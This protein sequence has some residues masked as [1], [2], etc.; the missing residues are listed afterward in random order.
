MNLTVDNLNIGGLDY[1]TKEGAQESLI[2]VDEAQAQV[3]S[4][5]ANLGALQNRFQSTVENLGAQHE[6]ISAANSRIRDTDIASATAEAAKNN[7]LLQ[8]SAGVLVQAN[9][10]PSLALKMIG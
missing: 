8:A 6:N 5:R 2:T 4:Y 3:A 7:V 10:I 9:Q 1:S